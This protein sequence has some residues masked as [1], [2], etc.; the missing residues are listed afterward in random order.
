MSPHERSTH[1]KNKHKND[2]FYHRILHYVNKEQV[3]YDFREMEIQIRVC[4]KWN[5]QMLWFLK[6]TSFNF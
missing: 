4:L 1:L 5:S 6:K 2:K 3:N